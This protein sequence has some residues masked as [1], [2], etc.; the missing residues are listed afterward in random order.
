[1]LMNVADDRLS[2][3]LNRDVLNAHRLL[4]FAAQASEGLN[5][6]GESP[7]HFHCQIGINLQLFGRLGVSG[8]SHKLGCQIVVLRHLDRQRGLYL[9]F[10]PNRFDDGEGRI[11]ARRVKFG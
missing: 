2:A 3:G 7:L 10:R 11:H 6:C 9:V 5:L 8:H 4:R 1:M